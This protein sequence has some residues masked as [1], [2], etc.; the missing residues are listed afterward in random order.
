MK[1][2]ILRLDQVEG[3]NRLEV[4]NRVGADAEVTDFASYR[5]AQAFPFKGKY[6]AAKGLEIESPI[7]D[8]KSA[9]YWTS[10][11]VS[12]SI[13]KCFSYGKLQSEETPAWSDD[14]GVR[15][16]V[17]IDQ[18][19]DQITDIETVDYG[20]G[21]VKIAKFGEYPQE[22][23]PM[24]EWER[25]NKAFEEGIM[26]PTAK[27]YSTWGYRTQLYYDGAERHFE[28]MECPEYEFEG[29]KYALVRPA[30]FEGDA[31]FDRGYTWMEVKPI[32]WYLDE[33]SGLAISKDILL[34][35]LPMSRKGIYLN[36]F[37][38]T[39]ISEF[40]ND[41]FALDSRIVENKKEMIDE[42]L[43]EPEDVFESKT[44]TL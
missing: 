37:D 30:V 6:L 11:K 42:M 26:K 1:Y 41:E 19:K 28:Q 17:P 31:T 10:T 7:L 39:I 5:G 18:I 22:K 16:C 27:S 8:K 21:E 44:K 35:G 13:A 25:F 12:G 36:N 23:I 15:I 38:K 32:E 43:E 2:S 14:I 34:G 3:K 33:Q 24:D 9:K 29:K 4:F 20:H 40:L